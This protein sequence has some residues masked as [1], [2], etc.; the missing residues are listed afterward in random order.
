MKD[1]LAFPAQQPATCRGHHGSN[2]SVSW[3]HE[4]RRSFLRGL[5]GGRGM[6]ARLRVAFGRINR[7]QLALV[8]QWAAWLRGVQAGRPLATQV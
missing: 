1:R 3:P 8:V 2:P 5:P 6:I 4:P 7:T